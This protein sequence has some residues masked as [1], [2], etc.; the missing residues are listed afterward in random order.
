MGGWKSSLAAIGPVLTLFANFFHL[1][2]AKRE[3]RSR[4]PTRNLRQKPPHRAGPGSAGQHK[5]DYVELEAAGAPRGAW[6]AY[7]ERERRRRE[8]TAL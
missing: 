6:K 8:A 2:H 1:L 5:Q 3:A 7:A 4:L